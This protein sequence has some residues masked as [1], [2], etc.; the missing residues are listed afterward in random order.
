METRVF[1]ASVNARIRE[2]SGAHATW[3]ASAPFCDLGPMSLPLSCPS[4]GI[5]P[6]VLIAVVGSMVRRWM[7][8]AAARL[9]RARDP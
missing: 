8:G 4:A 6:I 3:N 2:P 7:R 1:D 5:N 9:R